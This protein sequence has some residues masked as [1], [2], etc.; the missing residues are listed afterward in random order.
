MATRRSRSVDGARLNVSVSLSGAAA[1]EARPELA[2]Y[3]FSGGGELIGHVVLKDGKGV[4]SLTWERA[5]GG[6]RPDRHRA[7]A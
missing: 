3:G 5:P 1:D 6:A 7:D 2:A 4:L